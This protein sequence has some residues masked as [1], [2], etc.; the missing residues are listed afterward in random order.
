VTQQT[1]G[2]GPGNLPYA[3]VATAAPF[4]PVGAHQADTTIDTAQAL[5]IPPTATK[6]LMQAEAQDLRYTLD[7]STTP[8]GSV[9]FLLAAGDAQVIDL[10][11]G[12]VVTVIAA[13]AG[14]VV[15]YQAGK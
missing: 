2:F 5:T 1:I 8:T 4:T 3:T 10:A 12:I 11:G 6:V 7:G 15:Q 9:G 14:G 13:V